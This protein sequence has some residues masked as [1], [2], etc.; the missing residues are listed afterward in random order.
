[1]NELKINVN[2]WLTKY[3]ELHKDYKMQDLE[4]NKLE[5]AKAIRYIRYCTKDT[6]G[7][8]RCENCGE[9]TCSE[10]E[11]EMFKFCPL[12]GKKLKAGI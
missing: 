1:M 4:S 6:F 11:Q 12:C 9:M 5:L 8:I 2:S 3:Q 10:R 7:S